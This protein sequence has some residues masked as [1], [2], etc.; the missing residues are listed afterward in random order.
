V[1]RRTALLLSLI[2]PI[3]AAAQIPRLPGVRPVTPTPQRRDTLHDST[4]VKWPAPD[5]VMQRLMTKQGYSI[6]RY[7]GDT[8]YF[9]ANNRVLDLLAAGKRLAVVDRDSQT[10]VSDSGIYYTEAVRHGVSGGN[11]VITPPPNSGQADIK[12]HGRV[13]FDMGERS[14][15]VTS[16]RL[17]VNNGEMWYLDVD[18]AKVVQDTANGKSPTAYI[19][20]GSLTSCD[21]SIPDYHF[22][23]RDAKRTS[24]NTIVARPAILYIKDIPVLWLPFIFS[25]TRSGRHS[26]LLP[27][28]FGIGDIVR[29]SPTYRRNIEHFGYYWAL[30]DYVDFGT[31]L[32]WRSSAGSTLG[33][34]GWVRFNGDWDYKWINRFLGG[35]VGAAYTKYGNGPTNTA[36][37]WSHQQ[38]FSHDSHLTTNV[39]YVT[40]TVLQRQNTFNSYTALATIYSS[41]N[42]QTKL[43]PASLSLGATRKQ[44][45]GRQQVDQTFPTLSLTSTTISLGKAFSWT[46]S[47]S[48]NR[49]DVLSMDQPGLGA[50]VYRVDSVT[51]IRDSVISKSRGSS[52]ASM[53]FDSPIQIFGWDFKNSFHINQQRNNFAQNFPIYDVNTG[54]ITD[55]RVFAATYRTD[56][57][58]T[59]DFTLPA[60]AHNRF[61]LSPSFSLGNVDPGPFWVASER[62]NGQYVH[63]AKRISTGLSASPTLFGFFPGFGPFTRIRHAITPSVTFNWA[64]GGTVSD[65]YLTAIGRTR[66]G[67]L[68]DLEQQSISFGLNQNFQA[69]VRSKSDSNPDA[70]EK[71]DL[72]SINSTPLSYDFVRAK[73][74]ATTHAGHKGT[75]GL[76]TETWGYSLRS[77]LLPGFD[78]SSQ[79]SLFSGSTLSDTAKFK[80]YL[81]SVSA[82]F[83][84]SRDQNPFSI[85]TRLFGKAVPEAQKS[86]NPSTDQ[87]RSL[88]DSAQ[89]AAIAAQPVAGGIR[90]GDRFIIPPTQGWRASFAFTHSSPRPPSC[91]NVPCGAANN[92][93]D[94]DPRL[95]CQQLFGVNPLLVDACLA[96]TQNVGTAE[97]PVTSLTVG[98][99]VYRIPATT[100]LNSDMSFNLTPKWAAKWTTTYDFERHEFASQNVGLQ[101]ELHDWRAIFGFTQSANGNFSF[102]FT[103]ALKAEPDLKFDYNRNTVR[104][105][106]PF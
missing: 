3:T 52:T 5:S 2:L 4:R 98:G 87:V 64:P 58:W 55:T 17:P 37:S 61:N 57:D 70:G 34:P 1:T 82:S 48:F 11:Y 88:P 72:L 104:S 49:S 46:P 69:K 45:P 33:D 80:P 16:A 90:G 50:Y 76:T 103:I 63:Q 42:Y 27:P 99:P 100:S 43:G 6:T 19:R 102:N 41:V 62:T 36:V 44:Y 28:Q 60:F 65:E 54:A 8:A 93:I 18:L 85:F 84:I 24:N 51:R 77:D 56:V 21:D 29:N 30:N 47:F 101:R 96:Q 89:S 67:Y 71:V 59:P 39:N 105:G 26:G 14:V 13:D 94:Y 25:D 106:V 15:R 35:R 73:Q 9:D 74:F 66:K 68:G 40:S 22:E 10:V 12:G 78:F 79:Y 20:G 32:D 38:D 86:P 53:T 31:W 81:T 91:G 7:I 83:N 75:A 97:T 95:R 23:Y 92:V